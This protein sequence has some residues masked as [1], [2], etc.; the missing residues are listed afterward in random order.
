MLTGTGIVPPNE[1]TLHEGD[2]G[3]HRHRWG[4][5]VD[6]HGKGCVMTITDDILGS[7][8]TLRETRLSGEGPQGRLPPPR[9]A[10]REEP[11]GNLFG[12]TQ[13][14]AMGWSPEEVGLDH[15]CIVS[16]QGGLRAEDGSPLALGYHTGHWEIS[17]LVERAPADA[18]RPQQHSL[19]RLLLGSVRWAHPG[20]PGHVRQPALP[21]RCRHDDAPA[22]PVAAYAPG[23]DGHWHLRQGVARDYD[24]TRWYG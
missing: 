18:A 3:A 5:Y 11:S 24:G 9:D 13:N 6:Q 20:H 19:L 1:F 22:H 8:T 15:Y 21:Q 10:L 2:I 12:M 16:T 4:G 14:V 7:E 23:C 17:L